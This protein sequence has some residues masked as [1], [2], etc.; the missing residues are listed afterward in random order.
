MRNK[1]SR[2]LLLLSVV[3]IAGCT[4]K[5]PDRERISSALARSDSLHRNQPTHRFPQSWQGYPVAANADSD[6]VVRLNASP[7][8]HR[9]LGESIDF[10]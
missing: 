6:S 7:D 4:S 9:V 3:A 5:P 2:R 1:I 8:T 10:R